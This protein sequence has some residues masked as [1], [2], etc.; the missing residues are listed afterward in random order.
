MAAR[1]ATPRFVMGAAE[2]VPPVLSQRV[3]GEG[4]PLR[5]VNARGGNAPVML[6]QGVWRGTP[7][8]SP[9]LAVT[10]CVQAAAMS[11]WS[12][13]DCLVAGHGAAGHGAVAP[14]L[15]PHRSCP[16]PVRRAERSSSGA[17]WPGRQA[18]RD[19]QACGRRLLGDAATSADE[20]TD[21]HEATHGEEAAAW[22]VQ[23][24]ECP[25]ASELAGLLAA[26]VGTMLLA[27]AWSAEGA[28]WRHAGSQADAAAPRSNLSVA[29]MWVNPAVRMGEDGRG[30]AVRMSRR[31]SSG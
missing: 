5:I 10:L 21:G 28:C 20:F 17:A 4:T 26:V 29:A 30:G 8:G 18:C 2:G 12:P 15:P 1:L 22:H 3:S 7:L 19:G 6:R 24:G 14:P 23:G 11:A 9:V 16:A 31:A 13:E 25:S 27:M